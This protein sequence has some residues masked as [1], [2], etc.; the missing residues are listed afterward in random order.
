MSPGLASL[1]STLRS[2]P[3]ATLALSATN[4]RVL[5][6]AAQGRILAIE[7][8]GEPSSVRSV[9]VP[10]SVHR[11][12]TE[13]IAN[14]RT[15]QSIGN[16]NLR[17]IREAYDRNLVTWLRRIDDMAIAP[18]AWS[19]EQTS[20]PP[21]SSVVQGQTVARLMAMLEEKEMS[22][23]KVLSAAQTTVPE[24][25]ASGY[26]DMSTGML[27]AVRT[28]DNQPSEVL[29]LLAA[30]TADLFQGANV[31]AIEK[32]FKR[33]RGVAEDDHHFF[34]E[35]VVFS[36]N[37]LHVFLRSKKRQDHAL[38]YVCLGKANIGMV[39]SKARISLGQIEAAV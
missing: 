25:I 6:S 16:E 36:D 10:A 3:G 2:R 27:L 15:P 29:D 8:E 14:G 28:V 18:N 20:M 34:Q 1:L 32:I 4:P 7:I 39:L 23:E 26:V 9:R 5:V 33:A 17:T 11:A 31:T 12:A 24:C 37:L 30:A 38:V 21:P 13:A 19:Y 35:I 22:L